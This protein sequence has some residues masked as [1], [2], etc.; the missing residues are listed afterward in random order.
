MPK[1]VQIA[2][3]VVCLLGAGYLLVS[4]ATKNSPTAN[5]GIMDVY[6]FKCLKC[7]H[8]FAWERGEDIGSRENVDDCPECGTMEAA[9]CAICPNGHYQVMRGHGT[10]ERNCPECGVEMPPLREQK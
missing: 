9:R 3:V 4:Y 1:P 5:E 10:Y 7:G 2:I 6:H 8:E